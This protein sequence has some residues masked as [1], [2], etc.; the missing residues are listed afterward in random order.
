MSKRWHHRVGLALVIATPSVVLRTTGLELGPLPTAV[1]FGCAVVA[2][3]FLLSWAAEAAQA[4]ISASLATALLA[5]IA[6]LPEYAVDLYFSWAAGHHPEMAQFAAANMTGS[7]RL[8]IGFGW[9]LVILLAAMWARGHG[10]PTGAAVRIDRRSRVELVG[11]A[12]AGVF[13][14]TVPLSHRITLL[15]SSVL[16]VLYAG[17]I[18]RVSKE[19]RREPDLIGVAEQIAALP[20]A[21]RRAVVVGMFV[22]AAALI[23]A[24]AEP[25]ASALVASG[26]RLGLDEFLLV[27]WLAPLASEAPELLVAAFLARRGSAGAA[28]G[29]L[30]SSKLNQ[31]MLL[32]GSLPI[33]HALGGGGHGLPLDARQIEE[34]YLTATQTILGLAILIDMRF[35]VGEALTL[36]GLFLVQFVF[37][38]REARLVLSGVYLMVAIALLVRNRRFIPPLWRALMPSTPAPSHAMSVTST[39][40]PPAAGTGLGGRSTAGGGGT[41][42]GTHP[43]Q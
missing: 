32:V 20:R 13:A 10:R 6:V 33:A 8:L 7:N 40:G 17:Y 31:W 39:G 35:S 19:E 2:S 18:W 22:T 23:L 16:L 43:L 41:P 34:F 25:F 9:P 4:D 42:V 1:L 28:L 14:F 3:A 11:L 24:A 15:D 29:I 38:G 30:L 37:P 36:L 12:M 27:Q 5:L 21:T 26:K